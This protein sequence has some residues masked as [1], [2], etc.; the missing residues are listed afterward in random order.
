MQA[1]GGKA[2]ERML[3]AGTGLRSIGDEDEEDE[4]DGNGEQGE[5]IEILVGQD[6]EDD[7]YGGAVV[8][9]A[10]PSKRA[11]RA[12]NGS[13]PTTRKATTRRKARSATQEPDSDGDDATLVNVEELLEGIDFGAAHKHPGRLGLGAVGLGTGAY[14]AAPGALLSRAKGQGTADII[15]ASLLSEL[16]AL[17][18]ANIHSILN[19]DD[20]LLSVLNYVDE[21][22]GQLDTIDSLVASFKVSLNSRAEDIDFIESQNR[23]LQVMNSNWRALEREIEQLRQTV[24]VPS[25]EVQTLLDPNFDVVGAIEAK[26]AAAASL[27]KAILQAKTGQMEEHAHAGM[28]ATTERLGEYSSISTSFSQTMFSHLDAVFGQLTAALLADPSRKA[29]LQPPQPRLEPHDPVEA[30]LGIYCGLMLYVKEVEPKGFERISASYLTTASG[31]YKEEVTRVIGAWKMSIRR[32]G[33]EEEAIASFAPETTNS[34]SSLGMSSLSRAATTR[35][36]GGGGSHA[37]SGRKNRNG[38][39]EGEVSGA[40]ALNYVLLSVI[41][42]ILRE[43]LFISDFLHLNSNG[44]TFADYMDLET[45]F[46]RRAAALFGEEQ[47]GER[48]GGLREMKGAMELIFGFL[49][50]AVGEFIDEVEKKDRF[51]VVGMLGALDS[52]IAESEEANNEF[53]AR[54]LNRLQM[55]VNASADSFFA[56]QLKAVTMTTAAKSGTVGSSYAP[57]FRGRKSGR[58]GLTQAVRVLPHFVDR[59][60]SQLTNTQHLNVRSIVDGFYSQLTTT[61]IDALLSIKMEATTAT[62][63]QDEDKGVMNHHVLLIENMH[64]LVQEVTKLMVKAP[65]L[66]QLISRAEKVYEDSLSAYTHFVLRRPLGKMM[67]YGDGIDSLLRTTPANEVSLHSAYSK[68]SFR[69]LLKEFTSKDVRKQVDALWRRVLKHFDE[70]ENEGFSLS[71]VSSTSTSGTELMMGAQ[72]EEEER[73]VVVGKVWRRCEMDFKREFERIGRIGEECYKGAGGLEIRVDE[74][75]RLFAR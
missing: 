22:L 17:D 57:S 61:V 46:R 15:E 47:L 5:Q 71:K 24:N 2:Y 35:R 39:A 52:A 43:S 41:P 29:M 55:K 12:L 13:P 7:I 48:R 65:V 33:E 75:T 45:Y 31:S 23:G 54:T 10:S 50:G 72:A 8:E 4:E 40:E 60:E 16:E 27:Y 1:R 73:K 53:L 37:L 68:S 51:Q 69:K 59:L 74:I 66:S 42:L 58:G 11:N 67:D 49:V 70:D 64:H 34:T 18:S 32:P 6:E 9:D 25:S 56:A 20:R 36:L 30:A 21:A 14:S 26:E 19:G 3:L 28:A 44:L 38:S 62:G 63:G